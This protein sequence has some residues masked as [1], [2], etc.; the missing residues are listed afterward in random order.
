MLQF[1]LEQKVKVLFGAGCVS[2]TGEMAKEEGYNKAFVVYDQGVKDAGIADKVLK[3][4]D[5]AGI[6]YVT[7]DKVKSDP[8][9]YLIDEA[10]IICNN[11]KCDVVIG[12][13]GGSSMDTA[14]GINLLRFNK[15]QILDFAAMGT[16]INP[17]SGLI[18]IP[19][20]SGTGS[21]LSNGLVVTDTKKNVKVLMLNPDAMAN[22]TIIDPELM[23]GMPPGL[24]AFTGMD[25]LAH[26]CESCTTVLS[27]PITNQISEK[28]ISIIYEWLPIAVKDGKNIQAREYMAMAAS[29]GGWMLAQGCAHVGH[30]IAHT[31]GAIY[32]MPHGAACSY[33]L[34]HA[35]EFVA[36]AVPE[37]TKRIGM[38]MG[39]KFADN[40]TPEQIGVITRDAIIKFRDEV[41]NIKPI[42]EYNCDLNKL[43]ECA[44][45]IVVE[46]AAPLTPRS[47]ELKDAQNLLNKV[48]NIS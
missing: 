19:T 10:S 22:Y 11:E 40:E 1:Y 36:P 20:T 32:H 16:K 46:P 4:L 2:Q 47:V 17:C 13:G 8:P 43:Q 41:M 45:A 6:K 26:G 33:A 3:N 18:C 31:L 7:F 23:I 12:V 39:A 42:S 34:P 5:E 25:A 44:E 24:T 9:D 21:E 38:L 15:G 48:F 35:I 28:V 14:K 27:N 30:S 29:L 37:Q